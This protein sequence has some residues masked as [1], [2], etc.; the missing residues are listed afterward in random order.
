[1]RP[2][3]EVQCAFLAST[4]CRASC[5]GLR[6]ERAKSRPASAKN[7]TRASGAPPVGHYT[8]SVRRGAG[9]VGEVASHREPRGNR[10]LR[11][12]VADDVETATILLVVGSTVA[13]L[14]TRVAGRATSHRRAHASCEPSMGVET[15]LD[16][17]PL[18]DTGAEMPVH[19]RGREVGI[20]RAHV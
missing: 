15:T 14:V 8:G 7:A 17:S 19:V 10:W 3:R 4:W 18:P 16:R 9:V 11:N 5:S 2:R 6:Q 1:M 13:A 12:T 20:G